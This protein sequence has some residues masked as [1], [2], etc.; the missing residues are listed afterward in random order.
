[1]RAT[2]FARPVRRLRRSCHGR[3]RRCGE[4]PCRTRT[5]PRRARRRTGCCIEI[6]A[7]PRRRT[8]R[9]ARGDAIA[10]TSPV[11]TAHS[12]DLHEPL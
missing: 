10:R 6:G 1:M 2:T 11:T 9:R 5:T 4:R 7:V 3:P 8:N 12:T